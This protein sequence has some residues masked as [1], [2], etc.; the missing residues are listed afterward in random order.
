MRMKEMDGEGTEGGGKGYIEEEAKRKLVVKNSKTSEKA[1]AFREQFFF[2][3]D[4]GMMC[5]YACF[6]FPL[7]FF[8]FGG[9]LSSEALTHNLFF[10]FLK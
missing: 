3:Y 6:F 2:G 1:K 4:R 10:I 5:V 8:F 7:F 9:V